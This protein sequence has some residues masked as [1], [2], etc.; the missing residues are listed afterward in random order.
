MI[1]DWVCLQFI[2]VYNNT[3]NSTRG[4][5][6]YDEDAADRLK[7]SLSNPPILMYQQIDLI[8]L[9]NVYH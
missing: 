3:G 5:G 8:N 7:L 1:I 9:C 4:W 2:K 6:A